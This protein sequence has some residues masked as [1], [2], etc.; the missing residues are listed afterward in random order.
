[1]ARGGGILEVNGKVA[2]MAVPARKRNVAS[3]KGAFGEHWFGNRIHLDGFFVAVEVVTQHHGPPLDAGGEHAV[4][5]EPAAQLLVGGLESGDVLE[6]LLRERVQHVHSR[7]R[8]ALG[9]DDVETDQR[10][11]V[12][13]EQLV[14]QPRHHIA[15]PGPASD[16]PQAPLV[17]V[18]D[19]DARVSLA[20]HR[21]LQARV[22][23]D[24]IELVD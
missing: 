7:T 13:V 12:L 19:D 2:R 11:A 20:G 6:F 10:N 24:A 21:Q 23:D 8:V 17:D 15:A 9:P 18:E 3:G 4:E 1:M 22:I 14:H 16:L 5:V